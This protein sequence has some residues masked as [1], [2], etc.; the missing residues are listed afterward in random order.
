MNQV[1]RV[2]TVMLIVLAVFLLLGI[3]Q[4]ITLRHSLVASPRGQLV[5][6]YIKL[7]YCVYFAAVI[8]TLILRATKPDAGRVATTA[9][10]LAL[11]A[12]IPFGTVVGIFGLA[13]VDKEKW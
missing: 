10:N 3:G 4:M 13:K 6:D 11:L 7:I 1:N 8:L 9:L 12:M 5:V 2:Y